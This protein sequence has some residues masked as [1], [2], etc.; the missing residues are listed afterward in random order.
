M[1][2]GLLRGCVQQ[3]VGEWDSVEV[4]TPWRRECV[5]AG[6]EQGE[7]GAGKEPGETKDLWSRCCVGI[8]KRGELRGGAAGRQAGWLSEG[9][10][11]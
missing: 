1:A 4:R 6:W 7:K 2:A 3:A 5:G 8:R 9:L 11:N 10:G